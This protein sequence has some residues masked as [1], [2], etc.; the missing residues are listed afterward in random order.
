MKAEPRVSHCILCKSTLDTLQ[1]LPSLP[2]A[3]LIHSNQYNTSLI[4]P[5]N[6]YLPLFISP[7]VILIS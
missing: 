1:S 6:S 4:C 7:L 3:I 5:Q 2:T